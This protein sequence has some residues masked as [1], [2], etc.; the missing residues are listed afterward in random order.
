MRLIWF[1][2]RRSERRTANRGLQTDEHPPS[3]R[4][5]G[6]S[7]LNTRSS[8]RLCRLLLCCCFRAELEDHLA[9]ENPTMKRDDVCNLVDEWMVAAEKPEN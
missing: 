7:P 1:K 9:R 4:S 6:C 2:E 8:A 3:L 5:V